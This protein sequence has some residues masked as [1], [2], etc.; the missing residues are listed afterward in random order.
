MDELIAILPE[1]NSLS[2]VG[3]IFITTESGVMR[4][5]TEA[6]VSKSLYKQILQYS[7]YHID[8]DTERATVLGSL[9]GSYDERIWELRKTHQFQSLDYELH[10]AHISLT[11][12]PKCE[13]AFRYIRSLIQNVTDTERI[14]K[15][16]E[17]ARFLIKIRPR[18][19]LLWAHMNWLQQTFST[20]S[21]DLEWTEQWTKQHPS[22]SSA[23]SFLQNIM[24]K[25][26]LYLRDAFAMNTKAVLEY[27]GHESLWYHRRFLMESLKSSMELECFEES[28]IKPLKNS[29]GVNDLYQNVC[30]VYH[31][32][33]FFGFS[34]Q[35]EGSMTLSV[36]YER[37][38][39]QVAISDLY[40]TSYVEQ[41][42]C[43]EN[44]FR[45]LR[46][47]F[48]KNSCG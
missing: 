31:V 11:A 33:L 21:G 24:P 26:E 4:E 46:L 18:N 7:H 14:K 32:D 40:P 20:Q 10:L 44:H 45:W 12:K 35:S 34:C 23:F 47:L 25:D 41:K 28:E 36:R 5:G 17:F 30:D 13:G 43:A 37:L 42:R 38:L 6:V 3:D 1:I 16:V 29:F 9:V 39:I 8:D 19:Y 15:E 2:V 22:D 48:L 27:P